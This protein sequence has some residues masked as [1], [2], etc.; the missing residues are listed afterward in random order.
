MAIREGQASN[1]ACGLVLTIFG[2]FIVLFIFGFASMVIGADWA[3]VVGRSIRAH[4]FWTWLGSDLFWFFPGFLRPLPCNQ[5]VLVHFTPII[6]EGNRL[7][8]LA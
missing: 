3:E 1:I 5:G 8:L 4:W 7:T 2:S 6:A